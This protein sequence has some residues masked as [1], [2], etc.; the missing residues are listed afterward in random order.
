MYR[1]IEYTHTYKHPILIP[2]P[3]HIHIYIHIHTYTLRA[4]L[5][6]ASRPR[7]RAIWRSGHR[8][9]VE[10]AQLVPLRVALGGYHE[11]SFRA[12]IW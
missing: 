11:T 7:G 2:I 6:A 4:S 12:S 3:I 1:Y 9:R 5:R 10:P 8:A